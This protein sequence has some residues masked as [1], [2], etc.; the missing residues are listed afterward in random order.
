MKKRPPLLFAF[1][2]LAAVVCGLGILLVHGY[3]PGK[4]A[5]SAPQNWPAKSPRNTSRPKLVMFAHPKCPCTRASIGELA[6]LMTQCQGLVD[7]EVVFLRP[8]GAGEDWVHT[9]LWRSAAAIPGVG[10][11]SDEGGREASAF[12]ATTS[13][14]VVLYD[15]KGG[16]L[17]SGGITGGRGHAGDNS[18]RTA[19]LELLHHRPA[20]ES[21]TPTFGCSLTSPAA[22]PLQLETACM[23]PSI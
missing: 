23:R 12:R 9:D 21:R 1:I 3:T 7:A 6:V 5:G 10:V 20:P 22:T 14:H 13:G 15:A 2:W 16:L 19:I 11:R 4:D 18:G 17:F 8:K